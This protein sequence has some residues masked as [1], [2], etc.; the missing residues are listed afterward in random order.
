MEYIN[1]P[2]MNIGKLWWV[3]LGRGSVRSCALIDLATLSL[4]AHDGV[5]ESGVIRPRKLT[6]VTD[7]RLEHTVRFWVVVM[8]AIIIHLVHIGAHRAQVVSFDSFRWNQANYSEYCPSKDTLRP[9][10]CS[11][12]LRCLTHEAH[13]VKLEW[14][15]S[16]PFAEGMFV[17]V[18]KTKET[19]AARFCAV[20]HMAI[21][22]RATRLHHSQLVSRNCFGRT[23]TYYGEWCKAEKHSSLLRSRTMMANVIPETHVGIGRCFSR[24]LAKNAGQLLF[25]TQEIFITQVLIDAVIFNV[26]VFHESRV[27]NR[28]ENM[29]FDCFEW[30][31][32]EYDWWFKAMGLRLFL[33]GN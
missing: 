14:Y 6:V 21:D 18:I 5:Y 1:M 15:H 11:H 10:L 28:I 27:S 9:F 13:V 22:S 33:C 26:T 17:T 3:L 19:S 7:A 29:S 8:L 25:L 20:L 30:T 16:S 4:Q 32:V 12:F 23:Q 31:R 2:S 24:S